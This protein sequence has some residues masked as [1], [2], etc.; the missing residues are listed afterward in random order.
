M[1]QVRVEWNEM[2]PERSPTLRDQIEVLLEEAIS[3]SR[4]VDEYTKEPY[5]HRRAQV[6]ALVRIGDTLEEL[7][8]LQKAVTD[9]E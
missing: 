8:A 7:V 6:L 9:G 4:V 2:E 3:E 5:L 1:G